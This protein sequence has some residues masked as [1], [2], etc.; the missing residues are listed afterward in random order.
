[1]DQ[2]LGRR[3]IGLALSAAA[4]IVSACAETP[5]ASPGPAPQ[6]PPRVQ[7][8]PPAAQPQGPARLTA[9][10][11]LTARQR[12]RRAIELLNQGNPDQAR[13]EVEAFLA[14]QPDNELGR[15]LLEQI[16]RDPQ[17]LLGSQNYSYRV[18]PGET[19]SILAERF[20]GDRF[21]FWALARY[22]NIADPSRMSAGQTL[23]IPG[24]PRPVRPR[25]QAQTDEALIAS[26]V[27]GKPAPRPPAAAPAA[28]GRDPARAG[29][30]RGSALELMSR[31][32]I[33]RAVVMLEQALKLDPGNALIIRDLE[34]A[35]RLLTGR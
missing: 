17:A 24:T 12:V 32:V 35:R 31:G 30:L 23:M 27:E 11:G 26:R 34:R 10:P 21:K 29:Q 16:D 14:E 18:Q 5:T 8:T 19:I 15:S 20:L 33:D 6:P 2:A 9:T 7:P 25:T 4:L 28:Q 22:N 13:A 1:M 3:R